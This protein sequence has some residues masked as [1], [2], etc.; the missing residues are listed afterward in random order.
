MSESKI[1]VS[2]L[3]NFHLFASLPEEE[4]INLVNIM[5]LTELPA[6]HVIC[7]EGDPGD[8][9]YLVLDGI[10][11]VVK[12]LGSSD[13]RVFGQITPGDYFGEMSLLEHHGERTA[14]VRSLTAVRL[15][16]LWWSDFDALLVKWPNLAIDMLR[17]LSLRL[18]ETQNA[19]IRDLQKK[20]IQLSQAYKDLQAAQAQIIEKER[21][22][23]EVQ[24]AQ[25]IQMSMLPSGLPDTRGF[26]F[27]ARILPARTV[28]G[29]LYDFVPLGEMS[30]IGVLIGDVSDKGIPAALFMALSRSLL[31][32]EAS[33]GLP[34]VEVL[35]MVNRHLIDMN[36]SNMFVTM[37]Y[38][39]LRPETGDLLYARGGHEIPILVDASG[40]LIPINQS[41]G[42]LL[43][44]F[45]DPML[46]E[47]CVKIPPGGV[48]LLFT[49]GATDANN[50][51]GVFFGGERL[52]AALQQHREGTA[53]EICDR[54]FE[55]IIHFQGEADQM[56]D[57]TLV[58][59]RSHRA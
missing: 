53:Q 49:D 38:G 15:L 56:D 41:P 18:R 25:N 11:E 59:I 32:A 10:V 34:P 4:R 14:T 20:N 6:Q 28:G 30:D 42:Q 24:L 16:E 12:S 40:Q 44:L 13:E 5:H 2:S 21:L 19:A 35:Q 50:C 17:E 55:E 45:P 3:S 23:R 46:D 58:V 26:E 48:L 8:R 1:D 33:L 36:K 43:G 57:I 29:D 7:W 9:M 51:D 22:E 31:R 39:I 52:E 27:G 54:V 37:I 47:Q